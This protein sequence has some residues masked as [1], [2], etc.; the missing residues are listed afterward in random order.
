MTA[1]LRRKLLKHRVDV[2]YDEPGSGSKFIWFLFSHQGNIEQVARC[3]LVFSMPELLRDD[4]LHYTEPRP[5]H[6]E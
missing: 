3:L 1:S 4:L 5:R 6:V 2:P